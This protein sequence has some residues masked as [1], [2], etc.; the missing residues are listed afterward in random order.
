MRKPTKH[1]P[2]LDVG[3]PKSLEVASGLF[4]LLCI[5]IFHV[6]DE[7]QKDGNSSYTGIE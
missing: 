5:Q 4:K 2:N 7:F 3:F 1:P 6:V